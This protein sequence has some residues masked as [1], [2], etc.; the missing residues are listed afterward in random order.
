M[1]NEKRR[2]EFVESH[3]AGAWLAGHSRWSARRVSLSISIDSS[4]FY[5]CKLPRSASSA[6]HLQKKHSVSQTFQ[7][8]LAQFVRSFLF[9]LLRPASWPLP[10]ATSVLLPQRPITA[11]GPVPH[12]LDGPVDSC[13]L[14]VGHRGTAPHSHYLPTELEIHQ[15]RSAHALPI[16]PAHASHCYESSEGGGEYNRGLVESPGARDPE[17]ME[18][19][20]LTPSP[21]SMPSSHIP[22]PQT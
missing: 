19:Y 13:H 5:T 20:F 4:R 7:L 16:V 12:R 3:G 6:S 18:I 17:H 15:V 22:S 10:R 8:L 2:M 11:E 9:A 21:P 14:I 1:N